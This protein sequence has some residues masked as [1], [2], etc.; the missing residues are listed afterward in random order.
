MATSPRSQAWPVP[1]APR[2]APVEFAQPRRRSAADTQTF[3][4]TAAS[5][6]R[7]VPGGRRDGRTGTRRGRRHRCVSARRTDPAARHSRRDPVEGGGGQLLSHG[8]QLVLLRENWTGSA[9]LLLLRPETST[10][11]TIS[12]SAIRSANIRVVGRPSSTTARTTL[13][14]ILGKDRHLELAPKDWL[15]TRARLDPRELAAEFGPLA[16]P[17][18]AQQP[19]SD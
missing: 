6:A 7:A 18:P 4:P 15:V 9:S 2:G 13:D 1:P 12:S 11:A 8:P 3:R 17:A 19:A 14:E 16:I 10:R 5:A